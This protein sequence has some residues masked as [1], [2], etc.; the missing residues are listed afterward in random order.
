[1]EMYKFVNKKI[2]LKNNMFTSLVKSI[3][4]TQNSESIK[5]QTDQNKSCYIAHPGG[6]PRPC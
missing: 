5:S 2:L 3:N 1:M 4:K 6:V